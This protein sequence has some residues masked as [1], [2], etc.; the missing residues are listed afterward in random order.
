MSKRPFKKDAQAF[1]SLDGNFAFLVA[2]SL[3]PVI[4][5]AKERWCFVDYGTGYQ[6]E[7]DWKIWI[8]GL[9]IQQIKTHLPAFSCIPVL[10]V[11]SIWRIYTSTDC[12]HA[13]SAIIGFLLWQLI[14]FLSR[15]IRTLSLCLACSR[16]L[17]SRSG[18]KGFSC[19]LWI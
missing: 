9:C 10:V 12:R 8:C 14:V 1:A 19:L 2:Y 6:C 17:F 4:V 5:S 15:G 13:F 18:K 11:I 3:L 7:Q 16:L